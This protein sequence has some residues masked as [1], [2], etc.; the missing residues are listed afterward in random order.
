MRYTLIVFDRG[1]GY[2]E[3]FPILQ[4]CF[5]DEAIC[6]AQCGPINICQFS[7]NLTKDEISDRLLEKKIEFMLTDCD[8]ILTNYPKKIKD[9]FSNVP[10]LDEI[11][12][13]LSE[14]QPK[15]TKKKKSLQDQ[16]D[17]ALAKEDYEA[18]AGIKKLM[19]ENKHS[20]K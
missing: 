19:E 5:S 8:S 13:Y 14:K 20:L 6:A 16:L 18:A 7:S 1:V 2:P 10:K 17:E 3:E 11:E 9:H 4:S 12:N 15:S